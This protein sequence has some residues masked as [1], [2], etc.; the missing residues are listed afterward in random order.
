M[1][2]IVATKLLDVNTDGIPPEM[3]DKPNWL[4]WRLTRGANNRLNKIPVDPHTRGNGSST[5][6]TK[7]SDFETA[8]SVH[9]KHS[10]AI[11]GVGFVLT[12]DGIVCIDLDHSIDVDGV[13]LLWALEILEKFKGTYIEISVS[14]T[15]I[16]IF[17]RGV[18]P[19]GKCKKGNVE[20]YSTGRF[21]VATGQQLAP[22]SG[23]SLLDCSEA[24]ADLYRDTFATPAP[25]LLTPPAQARRQMSSGGMSPL[26][27]GR[28]LIAETPGAVSG[29][30]GHNATFH[31]ACML[32]KGCDL[33]TADALML[34]RE[35]NPKCSE[36]WTDSELVHKVDSADK[37]PD[38]RPRGY[39]LSRRERSLSVSVATLTEATAEATAAPLSEALQELARL[40][41]VLE[42]G[43]AGALY[44]DSKLLAAL[45][46]ASIAHKPE[47]AAAREAI[48]NAKPKI[49][50]PGLDKVLKPLIEQIK[51]LADKPMARDTTG[52]YF[53][54]D[55]CICREKNTSEDI[56]IVQLSNFVARIVDETTRDNGVETETV[57]GI[58]GTLANGRT[59]PRMEV[60]AKE[61]ATTKW[62]LRWSSDCIV[63]AGEERG[64]PAAVQAISQ[65]NKA[66]KREYT[67][68]GWR[69]VDGKRH[70]VSAS[71]AICDQGLMP[72]AVDLPP[73][74]R[75]YSL[76]APTEGSKAVAAV[77]A[78]LSILDVVP[79]RIAF[80]L[81][82]AVFRASLGP[83]DFSI[84]L[85]GRTGCGKT[86]V[87]AIFQQ[88]FGKELDAGHL[89]G[90]WLSTA[91][92]LEELL[93]AAADV[94]VVIDDLAPEGTASDISR[95]M[96]V[97]HKVLRSVGNHQSRGR[98]RPDGTARPDKPPRGLVLSTAETSPTAHSAMART[99]NIDIKPD[100]IHLP[101]LT[102]LQ[103]LAG[104]GVFASVKSNY[105]MYLATLQGD[106]AAKVRE[107]VVAFRDEAAAQMSGLHART[108]GIVAE[109]TVGWRFFLHFAV[110]TKAI[111]PEEA[112]TLKSR[113]WEALLQAA[114]SQRGE[115]A[116]CDPVGQFTRLLGAVVGSGRGYVAYVDGG[117]PA[118]PGGL[119]WRCE[120]IRS[121]TSCGNVWRPMGRRVG[122]TDGDSLFLDGDIA[123][124]ESQML[125][126]SQG[127]SLAISPGV[128][129]KR[130]NEKNL[131]ASTDLTKRE[132]LK[133]RRR[134]EG[135][136]RQVLHF[137]L[138]DVFH[139]A[140][141][142]DDGTF[143][144]AV[145]DESGAGERF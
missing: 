129:W 21:I 118:T 4:C 57:F 111:S 22:Y 107:R 33:S 93:F 85:S 137:R 49:R 23:A 7:W 39:L 89:P 56:V 130:C 68:L 50:L 133:T 58:E 30:G 74:L 29:S 136:D 78:V 10:K 142:D 126:T 124:S 16:H 116:A 5:D 63:W 20:L 122:W 34:L 61:F 35:W 18:K 125:A 14:A 71:G 31:M 72:V 43:G 28:K 110:T 106:L 109:L 51:R 108:P 105:L 27:M 104:E 13:I 138:S 79:A 114:Q 60:T 120:E 11:A 113:C 41:T 86:T 37:A 73:S 134:L 3:R 65:E 95:Q 97:F 12:G 127:E 1:S 119:G 42:A 70:F 82:S 6:P 15:G 132:T 112:A 117:Q 47:Y 143:Q 26:D 2:A 84:L 83:V 8:F 102:P 90:S 19:G 45:A 145:A 81:L 128:L 76:P 17:C 115:Q 64:F 139:M 75:R 53:M 52:G 66:R 24:I 131:L 36:E 99:L 59:L 141:G 54:A 38:D 87:A 32:V 135:I 69:S 121:A 144:T 91:N 9:K 94:L 96:A 92:S 80:P 40:P 25:S 77:R 123:F 46:L 62:W 44:A 67:S 48:A 88:F 100:E 98:M 55:G 103:K 101:S 140:G